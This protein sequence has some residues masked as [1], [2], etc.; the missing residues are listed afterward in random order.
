[1]AAQQSALATIQAGLASNTATINA[2]N[3][4][5]T[6]ATIPVG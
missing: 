2:Y 3:A 6:T 5:N 1:L 4:A